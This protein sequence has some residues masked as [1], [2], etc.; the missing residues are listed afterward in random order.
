MRDDID[1]AIDWRGLAAVFAE[2]QDLKRQSPAH[3]DGSI[4][5]GLYREAWGRYLVGESATDVADVVTAKALVSVLLPGCDERFWAPAGIPYDDAE[6]MMTGALSTTASGQLGDQTQAA[7]RRAVGEV[8]DEYERRSRGDELPDDYRGVE[9]PEDVEA[10]CRQPRA[11]AT[12]PGFARL[13]LVPPE[14]HAEHCILTGVYAALAAE[15]Y[16]AD[17]G[18]AFRA[19]LA[20]HLHNALL[21]DCG[22]AG[23]VLLGD[24]LDGVIARGR[25]R[26]LRQLPDHV[27]DP[28]RSAL[29]HHETIRSPEG[30]AVSA[31]DVIDRV[32]DVKWRTRAAAVTDADILSDLDLVHE[33]PLKDFQSD[34]LAHAGLW[35][36]VPADAP[37]RNQTIAV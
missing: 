15:Y 7:L 20:H 2:V 10:L 3:L 8:R 24:H 36:E 21:P 19:G 17:R 37:G 30:R 5:T 12:R 32:L 22:F 4:A 28:T 14:M 13:V 27:A 1:T 11:G 26:A 35:G 33:G 18:L 25:E 31:A 9:L 29:A 16:G 34:L 23:E 6:E